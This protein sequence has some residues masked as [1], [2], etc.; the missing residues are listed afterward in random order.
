MT[1][2]LRGHLRAVLLGVVDPFALQRLRIPGTDAA[3]YL[4]GVR[5]LLTAAAPARLGSASGSRRDASGDNGR[6]AS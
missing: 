1:L 2:T 4:S 3:H 6:D 5:A